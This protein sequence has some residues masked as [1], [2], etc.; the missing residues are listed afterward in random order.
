MAGLD[1]LPEPAG[2]QLDLPLLEERASGLAFY[3][4]IAETGGLVNS[5]RDD[6]LDTYRR[7]R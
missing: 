3:Q 6:V 7:G 2:K 4:R 1:P 5:D